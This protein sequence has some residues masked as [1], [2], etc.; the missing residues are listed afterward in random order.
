MKKIYMAGVGGMLGEAFHK[1]YC[2][3]YNL[4]C[5]DKDVNEKWLS[6][7]D[8]RDFDEYRRQVL[9]FSPDY[10]FHIGAHTDLEYC[11]INEEDCYR[12]NTMAVENACYIANELNIP[13]LYISTA[14]I[15]DGKNK[16]YDDYDRPNPICHY[17]RSKFMGEIF[18]R[19]NVQ[20]HIICRAGWMM[21]GGPRKDKK[22]VNKIINQIKEGRKVL[23]VVNDKL[24]TPTLTYDFAKNTRFLLERRY[25]GLY[26]MVCDGETGRLEV[27][28]EIVN[29]LGLDDAVE[30]VEVDSDFFRSD[31]FAL[32]PNSER[33]IN[34][35]L[36]MRDANL[37]RDWRVCLHEYLDNHYSELKNPTL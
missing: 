33:L 21:G 28:K 24:G 18:V 2:N 5:T 16:L 32:R 10:L 12:T 31:Y 1:E 17:G 7:C 37:M 8:F 19:E 34:K 29:Y 26:N 3:E 20:R 30:I 6:F 14:G 4:L 15:F 23:N 36:D 9:D 11:E 25:W 35:K 22:F 13:L 27:A